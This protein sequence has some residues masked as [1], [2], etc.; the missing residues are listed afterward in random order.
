MTLLETPTPATHLSVQV[1]AASVTA[2]KT[3]QLIVSPLDAAG[4]LVPGYTGTVYLTSTDPH[5]RL[6]AHTF[7]AADHGNCAFTVTM[8]TAGN[9]DIVAHS[10]GGTGIGTIQVLAATATHLGVTAPATIAAGTPFDLTVAALDRFG[11][12]DPSFTGTIHLVTTDQA[13]GISLPVDYTFVSADQG[14]HTFTGG[15]TL[16]TVGRRTIS[17]TTI[18]ASV[19]GKAIVTVTPGALFGFSIIGLPSSVTSNSTRS[20]TLIAQDAYGN[21]I[22]NYEGTVQFSNAGGTA[23]LPSAYTFLPGNKGRHAFTVKFETP[24]VDQSLTVTDEADSNITGTKII[25]VT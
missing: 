5:A 2:G 14:V 16:L 4:H 23:I 25:T 18:G 19:A 22:T 9:Q 17:A 11:N 10:A 7:T 3:A 12:P 24:G 8:R 20:F 13:T 15:V 6:S 1:L 21:T